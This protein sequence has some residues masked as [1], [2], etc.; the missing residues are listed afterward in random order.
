[1]CCDSRYIRSNAWKRRKKL[2]TLFNKY[3]NEDIAI[4]FHAHNNLQL[5][6]SNALTFIN[7][8]KDKRE[9]VI[10]TSIYGMGRGAGNLPPEDGLE[11][12]FCLILKG[13]L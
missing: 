7:E 9:L 8:L 4:G 1:M 13:F 5:A 10:D 11:P 6:F 12:S 3:L 2:T